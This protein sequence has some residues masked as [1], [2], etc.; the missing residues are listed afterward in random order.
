MSNDFIL[1]N[2]YVRNKINDEGKQKKHIIT[3]SNNDNNSSYETN[4]I[5]NRGLTGNSNQ[6]I[7]INHSNIN[8]N[9]NKKTRISRI[10][11]DS[12][13]R[14][15]E[16]K[17]ILDSQIYYLNMNPFDIVYNK[18]TNETN[19]VIHH[20]NHSFKI[21]DN[22]IIQ[23][24]K[25]QTIT[26]ENGIEFINNSTYARIHHTNHGINFN[27]K[28]NIY[29]EIINFIG[30]MNNNTDYYNIPINIINRLH[31]IYPKISINEIQNNNYY[32]IN[33]ESII[34][35]FTSIYNLSYIQITFKDIN[36]INLN[37][38][39]SNYPITVNQ[40]N[41]FQTIYYV[42]KN[43]YKIKLNISN[44]ISVYGCGGDSVWIGKILDFIEGYIN[45]NFYKISLKKTFYNV[46][47]IKLIST[48]FPNTEKIIK[49]IPANKQN[50]MFYWKLL[51]DGDTIY[52]ITL[53]SGNYS[54]NLLQTTMNTL[55]E[56]ISRPTLQII[57]NNT[58]D[59]SYNI[60]MKCNINITPENDLFSIEFYTVIFVP[61]AIVYKSPN[62]F[63]DNNGRLIINHPNHR[64]VV[65]TNISIISA[66]ATDGIPIEVINNSFSIELIIDENTYQLKLPKFTSTSTVTTVT[67]GGSSMGIQFPVKSQLLFNYP[68]TI[69]KLIGYRN[70][71]NAESITNF[72]Y[73][74][75]N[76][77][78]YIYDNID[79]T[80]NYTNNSINLSGDNYILISSPIF[81]E[82]YN[83]GS[84]DNIFAKLLL[85][86]DPG[87]IMYNQFIQLGE[88]IPLLILTF[89]EWEVSF[90]NSNG[91][92]YD[93]GNLE[94]SYTLEI[95]EEI[96]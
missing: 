41:G 86:S 88:N 59:Y 15:R 87:T 4:Y 83:T 92:L 43:L 18:S 6:Q 93:F 55:I 52:S 26:I 22:I 71:G 80:L 51:S 44:D 82:S 96:D 14:N 68:N 32:Y 74:N 90:Y 29:I 13:D 61:N 79:Q 91:D 38:L 77:D 28:N 24:V 39:N 40:V 10:N 36:G 81:K 64:L 69:G 35:N 25:S 67:N 17:N 65:N 21:N 54:V 42:E 33:M 84:V 57:N 30:N 37:L 70:V 73:I 53:N 76:T 8:S 11:I 60:N 31:Q 49:S 94:H 2:N 34:A 9:I 3:S 75:Y 16:S 78:L 23:G 7:D 50:N 63:T 1:T 62:N 45:N 20:D 46:S 27:T 58:N 95:Y 89:S 19:L 85:S 72:N 56:K 47:K 5:M 12:K 48:E 66:L